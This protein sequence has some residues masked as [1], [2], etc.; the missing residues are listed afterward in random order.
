MPEFAVPTVP[1]PA[2]LLDAVM[3]SLKDTELRVLLVVARS[4]LGWKDPVTGGRKE[5][6]WISHAQMRRRTGRAGAAV[7]KA[8]ADLAGKGLLDVLGERGEALGTARRRQLY[9][10]RIYYRLSTRAHGSLEPGP[11]RNP[12]SGMRRRQKKKRNK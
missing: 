7:S 11:L 2:Y 9:G 6:D 8:V 1:L 4:T 3:P 12:D 5:R 10:G